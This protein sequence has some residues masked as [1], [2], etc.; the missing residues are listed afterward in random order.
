MHPWGLH[1][2]H[3]KLFKFVICDKFLESIVIEPM[4]K[5]PHAKKENVDL[6]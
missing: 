6:L 5:A 3:T 4:H 2:S 1:Q